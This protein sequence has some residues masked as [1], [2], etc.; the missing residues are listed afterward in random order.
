[1]SPGAEITPWEDAILP[2][3]GCRS[4]GI[5]RHAAITCA[6]PNPAN[7]WC[8][9]GG[10]YAKRTA[11]RVGARDPY[12]PLPL[13]RPVLHRF[14]LPVRP[15]LRFRIALSD[16]WTFPSLNPQGQNLRGHHPTSMAT[17]NG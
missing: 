15:G 14:C 10:G 1:M 9:T 4:Y 3:N 16:L 13:P 12:L 5:E 17:C 11:G 8:G 2:G 7:S 6:E